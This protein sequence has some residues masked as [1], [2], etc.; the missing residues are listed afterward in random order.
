MLFTLYNIKNLNDNNFCMWN[1]LLFLKNNKLLVSVI[2]IIKILFI[3]YGV[4]FL[5]DYLIPFLPK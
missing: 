5:V 2:I 4:P 1:F 3:L